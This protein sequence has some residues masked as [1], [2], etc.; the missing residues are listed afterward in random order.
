M[1]I[2]ELL[3]FYSFFIILFADSLFQ[4]FSGKNILGHEIINNRVS[5]FLVMI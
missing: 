5:S 4:F 1:I 2:E 3:N